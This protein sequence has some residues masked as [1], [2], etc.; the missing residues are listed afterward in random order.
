M[1]H[2]EAPLTVFL[3]D[4]GQDEESKVFVRF[5]PTAALNDVGAVVDY[6]QTLASIPVLLLKHEQ[7]ETTC[8]EYEVL[9]TPTKVIIGVS[10]PSDKPCDDLIEIVNWFAMN[11]L[12]VKILT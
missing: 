11:D 7:T 2:S 12:L 10:P 5:H 4:P 6:L 1:T 9:G 8:V 3:D